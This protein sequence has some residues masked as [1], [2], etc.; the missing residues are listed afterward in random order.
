MAR[1]PFD[2][3]LYGATGFT[4]Q[5]TAKYLSTVPDLQENGRSWA[6]AG[7][8]MRNIPR[9]GNSSFD[10]VPKGRSVCLQFVMDGP[11]E[12]SPN[13][14]KAILIRLLMKIIENS[15]C[16]CLGV[17]SVLAKVEAKNYPMVKNN[18]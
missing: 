18:S 11:F 7:R 1:K 4:G 8:D 3:V 6:I 16:Q 12:G 5:L 13:H 10:K 2:L 17:R 14:G 9:E 15:S